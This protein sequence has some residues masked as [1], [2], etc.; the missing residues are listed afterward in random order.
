MA[1]SDFDFFSGGSPTFG[2][3]TTGALI[4]TSSLEI[5]M[6]GATRIQG[7]PDSGNTRGFTKG[8][9]RSLFRCTAFTG[10]QTSINVGLFCLTSVEDVISTGTGDAYAVGI[11]PEDSVTNVTLRKITQ[12][13]GEFLS[14]GVLLD[15]AAKDFD[16]GTTI[17]MELQWNV[18]VP[19]LG[20]TQLI[21]RTGSQTDY[22]D[23][24]EVIN[25]ID[26]SSPYLTGFAEG[27]FCDC[28]SGQTATF[29]ID[30]T[31]TFVGT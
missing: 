26:T 8:K 22:S 12:N 28:D 1:L 3:Q 4:G 27:V 23:L 20:G 6:G 30:N 31:V 13:F 16:T 5:V 9:V 15:S 7:Q 11:Y 25:H 18:D 21:V 17:A 19:D 10:D 29:L 2:L 14:T 24:T